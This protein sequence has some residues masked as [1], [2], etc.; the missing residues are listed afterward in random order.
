MAAHIQAPQIADHENNLF[1]ATEI[2]AQL[3]GNHFL[4][5]TGCKGLLGCAGGTKDQPNPWL[6]MELAEEVKGGHQ[7]LLITLMPNDL[8]KADFYTPRVIND[9]YEIKENWLHFSHVYGEDLQELFT[10]HTGFLTSLF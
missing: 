7:R 3:G 1:V 10:E 6:R 4:T 5:M 2:L 9:E 8:Y